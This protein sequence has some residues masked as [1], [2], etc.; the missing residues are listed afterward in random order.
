MRARAPASAANLGPG[1]DVLAVALDRYV[2]VEVEPADRLTVT[3]DGEGSELPADASH[4][5]ARVASAV[6][7]H[8]RFAIRVRSEVPVARGLGSSAAIALAAAAAAGAEDPLGIAA[9][10]DGHADNAAAAFAGG[11]VAVNSLDDG[12]RVS[13]LPLDTG[14]GFVAVVPDRRLETARARAALPAEVPRADAVFNLGRLALLL[15]GL[16][17]R[18]KLVPAA[19]G[20]RLHQGPRTPLFAEAPAILA[21]LVQGGA[22]AACWSGAGPTLLGICEAGDAGRVADAGR[23]ALSRE[24]IAGRVLELHADV[25]G[26]VVGAG[27]ALPARGGVGEPPA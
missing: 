15:E 2:V 9:R 13:R 22:R 14:L 5:A 23:A 19:T 10:M 21:A 25:E 17:D 4:L 20:D 3:S 16:G 8:D 11:L 1:L 12:P 7:G 18:R 26:L 24:R 6:L 27:A